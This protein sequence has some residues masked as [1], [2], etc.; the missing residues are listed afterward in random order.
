MVALIPLRNPR[1]LA[2]IPNYSTDEVQFTEII[3]E[4][5]FGDV[6][7]AMWKGQHIAVKMIPLEMNR[8]TV[9]QA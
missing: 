6:W 3:G 9:E 1:E 7:R 4:G 8:S 2:V 5:C